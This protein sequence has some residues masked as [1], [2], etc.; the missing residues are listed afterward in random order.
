MRVLGHVTSSY[1]SATLGRSIALA[2]LENGRAR[3]DQ[4]LFAPM[5]DRAIGVRVVSPVFYDPQGARLHG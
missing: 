5:A 1:N 2:L 3:M 4:H